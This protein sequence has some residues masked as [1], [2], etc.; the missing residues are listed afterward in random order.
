MRVATFNPAGITAT[1]AA[2]KHISRQVALSGRPCLRLGVKQAG[3]NGYM[4]TLDHLDEPGADDQAFPIN[5][6]LALHVSASDL[7]LVRGTEVDLVKEGL[8][9]ALKFKNPNATAHC[10]CGES[11]SLDGETADA[12]PTDN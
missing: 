1:A 5:E 3:C 8:N 11:F 2:V 9:S 12:Q 4:Y 10:G 6:S 7:P